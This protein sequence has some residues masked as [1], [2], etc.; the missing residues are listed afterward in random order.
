MENWMSR[1]PD[2]KKLILINIPSTHDSTAYY[3]NCFFKNLAQTQYFN[4]KQQLEIGTRKI[5]IRV[6]DRNKKREEDE[7]IICCHGICDCYASDNFGNMKKL[8]FKSILIDIRNFLVQNPSETVMISVV[9]GRGKKTENETLKRAYE[10][11][12]KYVGD[13]FINYYHDIILGDARGKII[14]LTYFHHEINEKRVNKVVNYCN[15]N[16]G[17]GTGIEEVHKKY[18]SYRPFKVNGNLKI[19]EIKDMF[20]KY[21]MTLQEAEIEEIEILNYFQ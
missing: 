11:F 2:T 17:Y 5:D 12:H 20:T 6:A 21:K 14:N 8:T 7:D 19:H 4:I 13:I 16:L 1:I 18:R 9:L 10:I 15:F 3:I